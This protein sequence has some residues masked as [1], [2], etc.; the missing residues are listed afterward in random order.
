MANEVANV[1]GFGLAKIAQGLKRTRAAA[2]SFGGKPFLKFGRDGT[3]NLGKA[4]EEVNGETAILNI[5]SL[6]TGYVCW[7]DYSAEELAARKKKGQPAKNQKVGEEMKLAVLGGVDFEDL[8]ETEWE[9][10]QQQ[11]IEGRFTDGQK[12]E[13]SYT[14]SS[15]GGLECFDGVIGAVME[16]INNGEQVFLNPIVRFDDEW[17]DHA[18][19]GKT[20]KPILLIVGWADEDGVPEDAE[21]EASVPK[22]TKK[23]RPAKKP[24]PEPEPE[25]DEGYDDGT[26]WVEEDE[27]EGPEAPEEDEGEQEE[28]E[29][30]APVRRR[31]R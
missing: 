27:E 12:R 30:T 14:T 20:Y 4:N 2:P 21:E 7:T 10:T 3:W 1:G 5:S 23:K 9:W 26:K 19:W 17:Y 18:T 11:T 8:P 29:T 13:F 31:R 22:V 24:E 6:K 25:E 28:P 15:L 16:R